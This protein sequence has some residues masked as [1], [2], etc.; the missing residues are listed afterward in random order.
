MNFRTQEARTFAPTVSE[1]CG[2]LNR[3]AAEESENRFRRE[4]LEHMSKSKFEATSELYEYIS[5]P[6]S[7]PQTRIAFRATAA[8]RQEIK[9]WYASMRE[10][11]K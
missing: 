6:A 2:M 4:K 8:R 1:F 9:E 5:G 7:A 11:N 10:A 3:F